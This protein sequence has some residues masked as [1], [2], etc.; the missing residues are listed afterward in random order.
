M[1]PCAGCL[2]FSVSPDGSRA[3]LTVLRQDGGGGADIWVWSFESRTLSRLTFESQVQVFPAWSPDSQRIVYRTLEGIYWRPAD[4]TGAAEQLWATANNAALYEVTTDSEL[5]FTQAPSGSEALDIFTFDPTSEG[6]PRAL[7]GSSFVEDRPALSPDGRWLAY[8]SDETGQR[9]IYVRPYP[10][11]DTGKWQVST[12]GGAQ[13]IW[14]PDQSKLHFIADSQL[15]QA[16]VETESAFER[17]TPE[18]LFDLDGFQIGA[19]SMRN[20]DVSADGERFLMMKAGSGSATDQGAFQVIV[21][22]NW[23][24]DLKRLVPTN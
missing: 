23:V 6:D 5:I 16:E 11:V 2:D 14:S 24:E 8:E 21:V 20:Y 10:D 9:E 3:A 15:M 4:G 1:E 17:R 18:P 7:L 12:N 13:P 19:G 22:Q